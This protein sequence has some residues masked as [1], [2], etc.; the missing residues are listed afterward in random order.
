MKYKQ[1]SEK[2]AGYRKNIAE[3]REKM[4][5]TL[6]ETEPEEVRDYEFPVS[7]GK[8]RLSELFCKNDELFMVHTM[9]RKQSV[10]GKFIDANNG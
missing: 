10:M 6:A 5:K 1:A 2:L 8:R 4:R 3:L 9:G 7:D